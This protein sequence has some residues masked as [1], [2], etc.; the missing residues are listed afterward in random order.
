MPFDKKDALVGPPA[1]SSCVSA[2]ALPCAYS[3]LLAA[4]F[5]LIRQL[6]FQCWSQFLI[7]LKYAKGLGEE[8]Q[9]PLPSRG[10]VLNQRD[11]TAGHPAQSFFQ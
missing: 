7:L 8:L 9:F 6:R 10:P 1:S 2:T 4:F 5:I 11:P 3:L